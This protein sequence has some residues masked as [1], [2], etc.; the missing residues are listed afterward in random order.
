MAQRQAGRTHPTKG[1]GRGLLSAAL[2]AGA[3]GCGGAESPTQAPPA[4]TSGR[5]VAWPAPPGEPASADYAVSVNGLPVFCY[6]TYRFD[7]SSS[8]TLTGRPVSPVSFCTFDMEGEV[9][10]EVRLLGGLAQA[11]VDTTSVCVRPLAR[12]LSPT[13]RNGAFAFRLS[14]PGP[15]TVEPGRGLQHPLHIFANPPEREVPAPNAPGVLYFG[16]GLHELGETEIKDGQTVYVAGGAILSLRPAPPDKL[17]RPEKVYGVDVSH[18]PGM[19]L[20][21][22]HKNVTIRGRGILC[23]RKALAEHQ[24]GPL[25][26]VEWC[27]G[28]TVEGV[29]IREASVWSLNVV[30]STRV[31]I[32]NV[33]VLG[34]YANNDGICIG[35]SSAVIVEDSF[36]HNADDSFEIK[37]WVPMQDVTF[38][39]CVVWND[40]GGALGLCCETDADVSHVV[41][42]DCTVLHAACESTS[43]GAIG[44]ALEGAGNAQDFRFERITIED[45]RGGRHAALKVINNWDDWHMDLPTKPDSPYELRSPLPRRTPR[46]RITGVL[47]RDITVLRSEL[48]DIVVMADS[49]ASPVQDILFEN[50]TLNGRRLQPDDPRLKTNAWVS[51][52]EVR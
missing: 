35:G 9:T 1:S 25:L 4:P 45:V 15:L 40:V 41:Y 47:F 20:S 29:I 39:R 42:Q 27:Q 7:R 34:H 51:G 33:K 2:V 36:C 46:G 30:N 6:T 28:L 50:V 12:G 13:L 44:L 24:R 49:A 17:Q 21:N 37:A 3:L 26:K 43:R 8:Q 38:R 22:G 52:L 5:V 11:G 48:A 10:V 18:S 23:G 19:L 16:A 31:R 14:A 32:A